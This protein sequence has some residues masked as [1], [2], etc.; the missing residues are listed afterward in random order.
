[1]ETFPETN[2]YEGRN[3]IDRETEL[4]VGG[5]LKKPVI[6]VYEKDKGSGKYKKVATKGGEKYDFFGYRVSNFRELV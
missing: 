6:G 3:F 2:C 4:C 1:M 5:R